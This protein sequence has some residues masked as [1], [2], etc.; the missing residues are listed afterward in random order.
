MRLLLILLILVAGCLPTPRH[1]LYQQEARSLV[2][3]RVPGCRRIGV[4]EGRQVFRVEACN[5]VF[6]V[7]CT[8][9]H[10]HIR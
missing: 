8:N 2:S 10:C 6:V 5:E 1:V 4:S 7:Q 9:G 3:Q